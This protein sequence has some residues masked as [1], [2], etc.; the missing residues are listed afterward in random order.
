[1]TDE[2]RARKWGAEPAA[3]NVAVLIAQRLDLSESTEWAGD[4]GIA[5]IADEVAAALAAER[6]RCAILVEDHGEINGD[7]DKSISACAFD[8]KYG[9][10]DTISAA[11]RALGGT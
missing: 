2:E 9:R 6:E 4:E 1:M 7:D 5:E 10:H 8:K 3:W 11:I